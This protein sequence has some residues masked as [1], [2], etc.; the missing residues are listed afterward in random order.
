MSNKVY[1]LLNMYLG[2]V[3]QGSML[4]QVEVYDR[5]VYATTS[6]YLGYVEYGFII[7]EVGVQCIS[8][9]CLDYV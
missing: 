5:K 9:R 7:Y 3:K 1:G 2:Y 6:R 4:C 8:N